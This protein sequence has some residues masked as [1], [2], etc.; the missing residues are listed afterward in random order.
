MANPVDAVIKG[1]AL[2]SF[3]FTSDKT[4][5]GLGLNT[6]GFLW[7]CDGIWGPAIDGVSTTWG[8]SVYP[9]VATAW[10]ASV[11]AGVT[12]VWAAAFGA[13]T[14]EVCSS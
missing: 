10:G 9:V 11:Y 6:F 14:V 13:S 2:E 8:A 7:P 4:I 5:A 3:G 1:A 12:T